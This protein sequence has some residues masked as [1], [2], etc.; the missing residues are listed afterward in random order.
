[1]V[2]RRTG[3]QLCPFSAELESRLS[4]RLELFPFHR[5]APPEASEW[6][7]R[8]G[9]DVA[10][11]VTNGRIGCDA[12]M[13]GRLPGVEMIAIHGVGFDRV[14]L[15][16]ARARGIVVAN[17]PD[18][19][20]DDVADLAVGL[21]IA[22][23]RDI[24]AADSYVREGRWPRGEWPLRTRVSGKRF[25]ILG[26]GRIGQAIAARLQPFG[27]IAYAATTR[28][29]VPWRHL[30][31]AVTLARESDVLIVACAANERTN[32]LVGRDVI[33]ALGPDGYIVNV[34]R[35]SIIDEAA[36]AEA[37]DHGRLAGAALDVFVEEPHVPAGLKGSPRTVLT[38]HMGSATVETR[39][40]MAARMLANLDAFLAGASPPDRVI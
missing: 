32:G 13:L 27:P 18:V 29:P 17:T 26:L 31:D 28:K 37:L 19:L 9:A 38:P 7:A 6:L 3:I 15:A 12:E 16:A 34:A 11:V 21:T 35:G 22:L 10:V 1:M 2:T 25:G 33:A 8:H 20:T 24:P 14:A 40:A 30:P 23:L 36:L 5:L 39:Q 4:A